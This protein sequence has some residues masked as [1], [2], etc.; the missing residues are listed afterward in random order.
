M[1]KTV[2]LLVFGWALH[3]PAVDVSRG[4]VCPGEWNADFP[5]ARALA[6]KEHRP[7]LLVHTSHG[8]PLCARLNKAIEGEAFSQWQKDRNIL[9]AYVKTGGK[10]EIYRQTHDFIKT[11]ASDLP[12]FPYVCIYWPQEDG[13]TNRMAFSGRRG[14]MG[15]EKN[16][17]FS[18]E[19]MTALD[20]ALKDYLAKGKH[21]TIEQILADSTKTVTAQVNGSGGKV[22]K[23]P[24]TGLLPEGGTVSLEAI[25]EANALFVCWK[26]PA[27]KVAGFKQRLE[28]SGSMAA[29]PYVAEFRPKAT[30]PPPILSVAATSL[31]V[32]VGQKFSYMVAVDENCR[33]VRFRSKRLPP[34][35]KLD[36]L[37]GE[38]SGTPKRVGEHSISVM[39]T[40]SDTGKTV[41]TQQVNLMIVS[42]KSGI[43]GLEVE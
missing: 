12:G 31:C 41:K 7:L 13:S 38:L 33:P 24:E 5:A 11:I 1:K 14:G 17:L 25:P 43:G 15:E 18:V 34:G 4:P 30:C 40:G 32:R 39:V 23:H 21:K 36:S 9:M 27:G 35:L 2:S 8:C 3:L 10:D 19:L 22:V 28:V 26:D 42:G 20:H 16:R 37:S 6:H 29:G